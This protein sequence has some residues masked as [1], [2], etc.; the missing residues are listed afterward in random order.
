MN[1]ENPESGTATPTPTQ[2]PASIPE[3]INWRLWARRLLVCNPFFLCSAALLLFGVNQLSGE[4]KLFSEEIQNLL[5]NFSALQFYEV[6]VV[7]TAVV[8]ARRKVWYDSSLLV[9]LEQGLALVPFML[10]SQATM[11]GE[12]APEGL[13]LAWT[14]SLAGGAVALARYGAVRRWFPQF[15]LPPRALLMGALILAGNVALPLIFRPRMEKDVADW[16]EEN[17]VLWYVILPIVAAGAN[18]LRRPTRYGGLNS[19][20]QWLPLFTYALWVAGSAVHVWCVAHICDMPLHSHHLAPLACVVAWTLWNRRSDCILSPSLHWQRMILVL[21]IA[22]PLLAFNES[23]LFTLLAGATHLAY[24]FLW[25]RTADTWPLRSAVMH[26]VLASL[27][28]VIAGIPEDW[29]RAILPALSRPRCIVLACSF[30]VLLHAVRSQ[31]PELGLAGAMALGAGLMLNAS[32]IPINLHAIAQCSLVFLLLHSLRWSGEQQPGANAVRWLAAMAWTLDACVWTRELRWEAI[33][34][35]GFAAV[36]VLA[37]WLLVWW[38]RGQRGSVAL[39]VAA[40]V[41]L[42]SG[43]GNWLSRHGS[44][45]LIALLGSL[46]LFAIGIV[47]AWTRHRWENGGKAER[48]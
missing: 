29:G 23:H 7:L 20:R 36:L 10:I 48:G 25:L 43:P 5:F 8:L 13:S 47:V 22:A 38:L 35:V 44:E 15:N 2:D 39:P 32:L 4:E 17:L 46:V 28:L 24:V 40:T 16:Q 31:R 45:G 11:Q 9:V 37:A 19:E 42:C 1:P 6:L 41:V 34:F 26:L 30:F 18:L 3:P 14:L 12:A 27:A 21:T 33:L